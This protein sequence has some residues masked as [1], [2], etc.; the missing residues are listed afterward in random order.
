MIILPFTF[1]HHLS[2]FI[3][4]FILCFVKFITIT[5]EYRVIL[6]VYFFTKPIPSI[7]LLIAI[8]LGFLL[9][10]LFTWHL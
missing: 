4:P 5:T 6:Q 8:F 9:V 10:H 3:I 7:V 1:L 2:F